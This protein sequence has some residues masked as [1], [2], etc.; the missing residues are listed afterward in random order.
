MRA[1]WGRV[2]ARDRGGR[3]RRAVRQGVPALA[4]G[5]EHGGGLCSQRTGGFEAM[6]GMKSAAV[7]E[8]L[9][10]WKSRPA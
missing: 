8:F 4:V 5:G 9:V 1:G 6:R 2:E 7:T 3:C 10:R